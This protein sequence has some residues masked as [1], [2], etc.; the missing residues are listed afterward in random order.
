MP[1]NSRPTTDELLTIAAG[2]LEEV[3]QYLTDSGKSLGRWFRGLTVLASDPKPHGTQSTGDTK[4]QE[5]DT[6][7]HGALRVTR[8]GDRSA[9]LPLAPNGP[10]LAV[11][12]FGISPSNGQLV[13][14]ESG[15]I[16]FANREDAMTAA[17]GHEGEPPPTNAIISGIA[18][19]FSWWVQTGASLPDGRKGLKLML[20]LGNDDRMP[21]V[22]IGVI[23][24]LDL[25][26][27]IGYFGSGDNPTAAATWEQ[28]ASFPEI[29]ALKFALEQM[30]GQVA[31]MEAVL[32]ISSVKAMGLTKARYGL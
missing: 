27:H 6:G 30:I 31:S 20:V 15:T 7:T 10:F 18:T 13:R 1:D 3:K 11:S 2:Y 12:F 23:S 25:H 29:S 22:N 26:A 14:D 17:L 32:K 21:Y 8:T 9:V 28:S 24:P 5:S 19:Y 4:T 16:I